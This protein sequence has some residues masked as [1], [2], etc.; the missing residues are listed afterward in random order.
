MRTITLLSLLCLVLTGCSQPAAVPSVPSVSMEIGDTLPVYCP[1]VAI[2][3][4]ETLQCIALPETNTPP[5]TPDGGGHGSTVPP[6]PTDTETPTAA[7]T[8]TGTGTPT[9]TPTPLPTATVTPTSTSTVTPTAVATQ[10]PLALADFP[11]CPDHDPDFWHPMV[12]YGR[13]CHFDHEHGVNPDGFAIASVM[14]GLGAPSL[15]EWNGGVDFGYPWQT[16]A[17]NVNKHRGYKGQSAVNLPH[18][19]Q[20]YTYMPQSKR[21]YIDAFNIVF[22]QDHGVREGYGRFHSFTAFVAVQDFAGDKGYI[23]TG[24]LSDTGDI[25]SPYKKTCRNPAFGDRPVCPTDPAVWAE[26]LNNPPYWAYTT[27]T[28]ALKLL[29]WGDLERNNPNVLSLPGNRVVWENYSADRTPSTGNRLGAAN[30]LMH[31]N[32]RTYNSSVYFDPADGLFKYVCPDGSCIATND[33]VHIYA[34]VVELPNSLPVDA[35]GFINYDGFTDRAGRI[36]TSC[37]AAGPLCVPLKIHN[38]KPGLYIYD[39]AEGFLPGART[40]GDGVQ[41]AQYT[42]RYFDET[43]AGAK[44]PNDPSKNCSWI[45]LPT[46]LG[47]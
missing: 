43:P 15:R 32:S 10:R 17:E 45:K 13:Q 4:G 20:N 16:T 24:G 38:A 47:E 31:F 28:D 2:V 14:Q 1:G 39:M 12:D 46:E 6:M 35:N 41:T 8:A 9:S 27:V 26:Q 5:P 25:H 33:A 42:V 40:W 37:T 21:M 30:L 29:D 11:L 22:H 3:V 18:V 19:Q 44:C 34:V 36:N 7:P 23:M